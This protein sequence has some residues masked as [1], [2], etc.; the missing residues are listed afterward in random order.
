LFTRWEYQQ[1]QRRIS[2]VK[3]DGKGREGKGAEKEEG[4]SRTP[5]GKNSNDVDFL[6]FCTGLTPL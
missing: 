4:I 6:S 5:T 2:R 1:Q 3:E